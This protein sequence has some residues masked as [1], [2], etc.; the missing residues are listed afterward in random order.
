MTRK[1][2]SFS[3]VAWSIT[4]LD[5]NFAGFDLGRIRFQIHADGRALGLAGREI[6]PAIVLGTF[7]EVVHHE[8]A[9]QMDVLM[10]A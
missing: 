4:K 8:A 5:E 3:R 6:E 1:W 7:D 9:G 2:I 10:R